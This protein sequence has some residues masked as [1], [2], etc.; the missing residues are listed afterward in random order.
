MNPEP[1]ISKAAQMLWAPIPAGAKPR[2]KKQKA[3]KTLEVGRQL[4]L[5]HA[6]FDGRNWCE[7]G[8]LFTVVQVTNLGVLLVNEKTLQDVSWS[9]EWKEVFK[10]VSKKTKK[11]VKKNP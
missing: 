1:D 7:T 5:L 10:K 3:W 2:V 4:V 11:K 6:W 9:R 8:D